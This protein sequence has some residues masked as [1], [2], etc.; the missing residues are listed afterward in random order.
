MMASVLIATD[1]FILACCFIESVMVPPWMFALTS[2]IFGGVIIFF[3]ALKL[4]VQIKD[5]VVTVRFLKRYVI[6]FGEILDHKVDDIDVVR[7]F[8]GWGL[9]K[10]TIKNC[11]CAGYEK[12]IALKVA[13]R[14]VIVISLSDPERFASLLPAPQSRL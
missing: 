13:G 2:V 6:P 14:K 5:S 4:R 1:F 9:K 10:V 3:A 11:I 7:N 8:S 12:G